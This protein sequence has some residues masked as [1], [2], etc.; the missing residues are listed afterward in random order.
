MDFLP[1]C[2]SLLSVLYGDQVAFQRWFL[3]LLLDT[4]ALSYLCTHALSPSPWLVLLSLCLASLSLASLLVSVQGYSIFHCVLSIGLCL[5]TVGGW[6]SA[7]RGPAATHTSPPHWLPLLYLSQAAFLA[8]SSILRVSS[9]TDTLLAWL[10]L[11][12]AAVVAALAAA[13]YCGALARAGGSAAAAGSS[14]DE[15][16]APLLGDASE[17]MEA[18]KPSHSLHDAASHLSVWSFSWMDALFATGLQRQL[19]LDDLEGLP[20]QDATEQAS[21]TLEAALAATPGQPRASLVWALLRCYGWPWA[22]VGALQ[23]GC[24]VAALVAPLALKGLLEYLQS[25]SSSSSDSTPLQ[26]LGWVALLAA[27]QV[28]SAVCT[29]QLSYRVARLQLRVRGGLVSALQRRVLAAPLGVRRG[30]SS[31]RVTNLVSV[32]VDR[33]LNLIPSFHQFWTLPLQVVAVIVELQ[34]QVSYAALGGVGV[35]LVMVPLNILVAQWLGS[36]TGV[37]MKA[38]DGRVQATG[39]VLSGMRAVKLSGWEVPL[40]ARIASHRASEFLALTKRKYL[41][42]ICVW[43]WASTPLLMSLATFALTLLLPSGGA[44]FT[45]AKVWASLA[46]LN[47]LI[48]PLNAFPWVLAGLLEARVSLQRLDDFLVGGPEDSKVQHS[49]L[50]TT[51]LIDCSDS[52]SSSSSSS[53]EVLVLARGDFVHA[54]GE[55]AEQGSEADKSEGKSTPLAAVHTP[56]EVVPG[57]PSAPS[58]FVLQLGQQGVAVRRAELVCVCGPMASGKSTLLL[59]LLGE[60]CAASSTDPGSASTHVTSASTFSYAPQL[61]WIRDGTV[62]ENVALGAQVESERL[63][64]VLAIAGLTEEVAERGALTAVTETAL[65]GGQRA[66]I[67]LARALYSRS[68]VLLLDNV[69]SALDASVG[70]AVWSATLGFCREE[71]RACVA[72]VSD[73]RFLAGVDRVVVLQA[74]AVLFSGS[75]SALPPATATA[76]GLRLVSGQAGG[77]LLG[78]SSS[79]TAAEA[80]EGGSLPAPSA[81]VLPLGCAAPSPSAEP[82]EEAAEEEF[83]EK[84]FV[85]GSVLQEYAQAAG[86]SLACF[87]L[88]SA[89]AMQ[90]TRNGADAWL[91]VWSSSTVQNSASDPFSALARFLVA[92]QWSTWDFLTVY[93]AMAGANFVLTALRAWSFARAGLQAA[94]SLHTRLLVGVVGA[95]QSFHDSTPSGRLLNRLSGDIFAIDDSLPFSVNILLSQFVGLLGT[96]VILGV[97]TFGLFL[98]LLPIL[99]LSFLHLQTRY[100]ATSRELK[101]LDSTTRSPLLTQFLD[102][103][104]GEAVLLAASLHRPLPASPVERERLRGLAHL[105]HSQRTTFT[106]SMAGQWLGLRLQLLGILILGVLCLFCFLLRLFSTPAQAAL[107]DDACPPPAAP[108]QGSSSSSSCCCSP[109]PSA[110]TNLGSASVAGLVLSLSLPVVYQLQGLLGAFTDTEKEFISVERTLEYASLCPEDAASSRSMATALAAPPSSS[111]ATAGSAPPPSCGAP[112]TMASAWSS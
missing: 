18:S 40:L 106:S 91:S 65:S 43:C 63:Q 87:A 82:G 45:P 95:A 96:V 92:R 111:T 27:I 13:V 89:L 90:A 5:A 21:A 99:C 36:L 66:R 30:L 112:L 77:A 54:A 60:L 62:A 24:V 9:C 46:M 101:R 3:V 94:A 29:T 57:Q 55:A 100:R 2:S 58:T 11:T 76:S 39:E 17:P 32:D 68:A 14:P 102:M 48:F 73:A 10:D 93:A 64:R 85:K 20:Q 8:H 74:G 19:N 105:D 88:V 69:T 72:V 81:T 28:A 80:A 38:R 49:T 51:E 34:A 67:G 16:A 109:A 47:L 35:L 84:G 26:G 23:V 7:P 59:A 56:G 1:P 98:L 97:S 110:S 104:K 86:W 15:A 70:S 78:G 52:S 22:V 12:L 4:T 79:S 71:G 41:D 108:A 50:C 83:R 107:Y 61:P 103:R 42:A 37:M 25:S 33:V 44:F 6:C 53:R 31:G 75:P